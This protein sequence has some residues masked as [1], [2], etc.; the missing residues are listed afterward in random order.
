MFEAIEVLFSQTFL[1]RALAVG[2]IIS[3]CSALL[4]VSLV[5]KQFS[6]IGDGLSHVGFGA[7]AVATVAGW[8]P[9]YF[10]LPIVVIAAFLLLKMNESGKMRGDAAIALISTGAL[11]IG[12]MVTSMTTGVNIDIYNYMFG[13]ILTMS[14]NDVYLSIILSIVII[15]VFVANY[16]EIFSIT[17]D[18]S[19]AKATGTKVSMYNMLIAA[20][21][22]VT[23]VI[24]MRMMGALLISSLIIF[25]SITSMRLCKTYKS[26][27]LS[28]CFLSVLCFLVG[29]VVSIRFEAPTGAS[30]V[31]TN[32]FMFVIYYVLNQIREIN[33][34][35]KLFKFKKL[36]M[37]IVV[38]ITTIAILFAMLTGSV[39][40]Y[41]NTTT[42]ISIVAT[43]F[44]QYD[45]AR[46]IVGDNASITMLLSP[47]EES[48]S[49]DPT[50]QDI[51][52]IQD[53]DLFIYGGGESDDWV[54][55]MV[56][57]IDTSEITLIRFMDLVELY[58]EEVVE[59][60]QSEHATTSH[61]FVEVYDEHVW[62]SPI[63]AIA[64][65]EQICETICELDPDN[66][67]EYQANALSYINEL[68]ELDQAFE[69]VVQ[70]ATNE[71]IMIGDRFPFLYLVEEYDIDYYAA[72]SGCSSDV[73]ANPT[74][75]AYLIDKAN[76]EDIPVVFKVDLSTG[77]VAETISES[78][79]A[80]ILTL[81]SCHVI[82][83]D[84]FNNGETYISLMYRNVEALSIALGS[85]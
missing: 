78:S 54:T 58:E 66:S 43:S 48:H 18:E 19:F 35:K 3:L 15:I 30:V 70:T 37:A 40:V 67:D 79:D 17:F 60:M 80:Q 81:Y 53:C 22:A 72:F 62:T 5:L 41:E 47:G 2:V 85:E 16:S 42:S 64:F 71:C 23:I 73:E 10:S 4:G 14:T 28:S 84:D 39:T 33:P 38:I 36:L 25:P 65:V 8:S 77:L 32:I 57:T 20:L 68:Y 76:A 83:N 26:V 6:M 34:D 13:S 51:I 29:L 45:F 24:G 27:V 7:L 56:S 50:P 46:A 52:S 9:L 61:T 63:N 44:P 59:G 21:T 82:S 31:C 55:S 11:A 74:T 69:Q 49:Y 1:I 12:I 75:I